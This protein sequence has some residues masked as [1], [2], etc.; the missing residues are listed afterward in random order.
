MLA[1]KCLFAFL[2]FPLLLLVAGCQPSW[3]SQSPTG[4]ILYNKT[5]HSR[6]GKVVGYE[7]VHDFHN[8]T[9]PEAAVLIEQ[10][11][12]HTTVWGSCATCAATF[13]LKAQ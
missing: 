13:D 8:G 7:E 1:A 4:S 12:D 5:D 3:R 2:V 6:F 10:D 9:N 11:S